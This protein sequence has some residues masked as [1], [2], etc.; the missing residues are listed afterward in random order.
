[1]T[2]YTIDNKIFWLLDLKQVHSHMDVVLPSVRK[3][4][5]KEAHKIESQFAYRSEPITEELFS[6]I[7][8][9]I[10]KKYVVS[11]SS[12]YLDEEQRYALLREEFRSN[13][14]AQYHLLWVFSKDDPSEI[15][16]ATLYKHVPAQ[17]RFAFVHKG[18]DHAVTRQLG[19]KL[20]LDYWTEAIVQDAAIA[21]GCTYLSHGRDKHFRQN[22][23]L[24]LFK[25]KVGGKPLSGIINTTIGLNRD[26]LERMQI[27]QT[28]IESQ[29]LSVFFEDP[30]DFGLY[31][32]VQLFYKEESQ[33]PDLF[34][35]FEKIAQQAG[36]EVRSTIW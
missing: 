36:L 15:H 31:Q 2:N 27:T 30:N 6:E 23:G 24:H 3:L 1:M 29:D 20:S 13:S 28:E 21:L 7:F 11:K 34:R 16:G 22:P 33:K 32:A 17:R 25:L 18:Y 12:F 8:I 19:L 35:E 4:L 5:E 10:Y 14:E 9:P 26:G